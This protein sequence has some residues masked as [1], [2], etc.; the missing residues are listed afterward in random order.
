MGR[1]FACMWEQMGAKKLQFVSTR[2]I[3]RIAA[4]SFMYPDNYPNIAQTLTV[5]ELTQPEADV[6][7]KAA[8]GFPM[9]MAPCPVASTVKF[10]LNGAVEI[11]SLV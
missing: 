5:D 6:A 9:P 10:I 4:D 8:V 3:G 7:F 1:A 11:V 2:Y